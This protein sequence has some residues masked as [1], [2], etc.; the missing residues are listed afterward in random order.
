MDAF[1]ER[2]L[3]DHLV[4]IVIKCLESP[5]E[6]EQWDMAFKCSSRDILSNVFIAVAFNFK[7]RRHSLVVGYINEMS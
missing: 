3:T 5:E 4:G 6:K 2:T 7:S 1:L